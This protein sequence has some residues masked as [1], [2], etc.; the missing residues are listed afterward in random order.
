MDGA[1]KML[2]GMARYHRHRVHGLEHVPAEGPALFAVNHSLA[3]YDVGLLVLAVYKRTG[4]IM[5]GLGDRSLF[6]TPGLRDLVPRLGVVDADPRQ[7]RRLLDAG[8]LI[9][10]APGGMREALRT[11][12]QR[13]TVQWD[14]RQ[15]FA[16]LAIEAGVPVILGACPRADD[17]FTAY[18]NP[19]TPRIYDRLRLPLPLARGLG[20]TA[21]PRPIALTHT[22]RAPIQPPEVG[23]GG[24]EEV[25]GEFHDRLVWEMEGLMVRALERRL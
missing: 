17:V 9:V 2:E 20:P 1:R 19:L 21:I 11:R 25:L 5:R 13:Y 24:I 4:R 3:T 18:K 7:A 15:G 23:E 10:V 6:T 12:A 22:L 16:R 8:E 14:D